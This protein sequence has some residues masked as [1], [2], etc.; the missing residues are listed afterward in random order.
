M[1][2]SSSWNVS[3]QATCASV[4]EIRSNY[5]CLCEVYHVLRQEKQLPHYHDSDDELSFGLPLEPG[6]VE[7]CDFDNA[8][9]EG[10]WWTDDTGCHRWMSFVCKI[11]F[12]LKRLS[13][14]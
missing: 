12:F 5:Y 2:Q 13:E 14:N 6:Q 10:E 8:S 4:Q 11:R 3:R 1:R 7:I 9:E